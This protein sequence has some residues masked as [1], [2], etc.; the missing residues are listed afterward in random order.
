MKGIEVEMD[1]IKYFVK[2]VTKSKSL[3]F[4]QTDVWLFINTFNG[5]SIFHEERQDIT[6]RY[7]TKKH[8]KQF[9]LRSFEVIY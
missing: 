6:E 8:A 1:G 3:V 7:F 5:K 2:V 4:I 9:I